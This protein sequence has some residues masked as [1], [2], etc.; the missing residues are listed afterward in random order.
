MSMNSALI[1]L[2]ID[3]GGPV[4][5][6]E[7]KFAVQG[8]SGGVS[9]VFCEGVSFL[10]GTYACFD[11]NEGASWNF[12]NCQSHSGAFDPTGYSLVQRSIAGTGGTTTGST[13]TTVT[14]SANSFS[15]ADVGRQIAGP[16]IPLGS[17][18][19]T[20]VNSG[21]VKIDQAA[22]AAGSNLTFT[23]YQ[24][25]GAWISGKDTIISDCRFGNLLRLSADGG[26]M[27][28]S[29]CTFVD[30]TG[31]GGLSHILLEGNWLLSNCYLDS[32]PPAGS[33]GQLG[34]QLVHKVGAGQS[35]LSNCRFYQNAVSNN[36]MFTENDTATSVSIT[37]GVVLAPSTTKSFSALVNL[38]GGANFSCWISGLSI[39]SVTALQTSGSY[40]VLFASGSSTG[41]GLFTIDYIGYPFIGP[42][43]QA[44]GSGSAALGSNCPA[45]TVTQPYAWLKMATDDGSVVWVPAWK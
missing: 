44:T 33:G 10:N 43:N 2:V 8:G 42:G 24:G 36:V 14:D 27:S 17:V 31:S 26:L 37:G 15:N 22:T 19:V 9:S 4:A 12:H 41:V 29:H 34:S 40:P 5:N 45:G 23:V 28:N 21:S 39:G 13:A 38:A 1:N 25:D 6:Y 30:P 32:C 16:N 11:T 35:S 3:G 18:I 7:C 20:F